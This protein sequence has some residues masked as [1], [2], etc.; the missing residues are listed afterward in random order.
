MSTQRTITIEPHKSGS[1]RKNDFPKNYVSTTKYSIWNIVPKNLFEQFQRVANFWFLTVSI[2]QILPMNLS[3][4][5]KWATITPLSV[6]L[7]ITFCKDAYEDYRRHRDDHRVNN[8]FCH[9]ADRDAG[10]RTV[11]WKDVNVGDYVYLS[12][13][14]PIPADMIMLGTCNEDGVAYVDTAQLDGE[15]SLKP[16]FALEETMRMTADVKELW[17]LSGHIDTELPNA[18]VQSFNGAFFIHGHPR[19]I[20]VDIKS[21]ILRGSTVRNTKWVLGVVVFTG[22]DTKLVRNSKRTPAK[23]SHVERTANRLLGVV[24]GVLLLASAICTVTRAIWTNSEGAQATNW[25]WPQGLDPLRDNQ[26]LAFI[27]FM[28][29]YN[30]LIPI[31]LYVT[32][33]LVRTFQALLMEQDATMYHK[34]TDSFCRV[35]NSGLCESLGQVEFVLSDKTGTLT[36]NEMRFKACSIHGKTYGCWD[37]RIGPVEHH[38][39]MPP[40]R[41]CKPL[42]P[43]MCKPA[44]SPMDGL[45]LGTIQASAD[46]ARS[47]LAEL[48]PILERKNS[49]VSVDVN[50]GHPADG[51]TQS[52]G[53]TAGSSRS[54][55]GGLG[56]RISEM[57]GRK[58]SAVMPMDPNGIQLRGSMLG[59]VPPTITSEESLPGTSS[60]DSNASRIQ[61]PDEEEANWTAE[62]KRADEFFTCLATCHTVIPELRDPDRQDGPK[63]GT[64]EHL[65]EEAAS[66]ILFRSSSPDEEALIAA[67]RDYGFFFR[68]KKG[69]SIVVNVRGKDRYYEILVLNEFSSERKRM[70][71]LVRRLDGPPDSRMSNTRSKS[72]KGEESVTV[73]GGESD[74]EDGDPGSHAGPTQD[75]ARRKTYPAVLYAKGADN[76]MMERFAKVG[77]SH[78]EEQMRALNE[79]LNKFAS[80]GLRTLVVAKRE[81]SPDETERFVQKSLEAKGAILNRNK[82]FEQVADEM[83]RNF[84]LLGITAIEDKIQEQV[85]QTIDMLL[86]AGIKVWVLTGDKTETAINV[87]VACRLIDKSMKQY[88]LEFGRNKDVRKALVQVYNDIREQRDTHDGDFKYCVVVHGSDLYTIMQ[89]GEVLMQQLFLAI[90][91]SSVSVIACRLAPAQKGELVKLVRNSLQGNPVTLSIGD[92]ANDVSMIQE[93]HVGVGIVGLEGLQAANASDFAMG[94]FCFL[95]TLLLCHGRWNLRRIGIVICYS[96]YKNF[97]M[98]LPMFYFTFKN[99]FSG[100]TLFDSYLLMSYNLFFTSLPIMFTGVLDVDCSA[101]ICLRV[102]ALYLGG[103]DRHYFNLHMFVTWIGRGVIHAIAIF[104]VMISI[105]GTDLPNESG[106]TSDMLV[107]GSW[108][109]WTC[110]VVANNKLLLSVKSVFKS[111]VG[112]FGFSMTIFLPLLAFYSQYPLQQFGLNQDM[113]GVAPFL[114]S[115]PMS[116]MGLILVVSFCFL[117]DIALK[118]AHKVFNPDPIDI[119]QEVQA[120]Y[121]TGEWETSLHG[122]P[123][124]VSI[125]REPRYS[126]SR[127]EIHSLIKSLP[128]PSTRFHRL[129]AHGGLRLEPPLLP[130]SSDGYNLGRPSAASSPGAAL[131]KRVSILDHLAGSPHHGGSIL[132][133][134]LP[135]QSQILPAPEGGRASQVSMAP[136]RRNDVS[137]GPGAYQSDISDDIGLVL[138]AGGPEASIYLQICR[139]LEAIKSWQCVTMEVGDLGD[140]G[141][142]PMGALED[143]K[144]DHGPQ[145]AS[146][147]GNNEKDKTANLAEEKKQQA[148]MMTNNSKNNLEY[149]MFALSFTNSERE[150]EF[151]KYFNKQAAMVCTKMMILCCAAV[152]FFRLFD[153]LIYWEELREAPMR[154]SWTLMTIVGCFAVVK[155]TRTRLFERN[156]ISYTLVGMVTI[157]TGVQV[158]HVVSG[159]NGILSVSVMLMIFCGGFRI[160]FIHALPIALY[161]NIVFFVRYLLFFNFIE[162]KNRLSVAQSGPEMVAEYVI[163][164]LGV[165]IFSLHYSYALEKSIR[166][167]FVMYDSLD[168]SKQRALAHLRGMFPDAVVDR[169]VDKFRQEEVR[170]RKQVSSMTAGDSRFQDIEP[171]YEDRGTVTVLF[172][173]IYDFDS[174]TESLQ[175]TELVTLLD[176]VFSMFDRICD[177]RRVV[178]IETV[179][180]TYMSCAMSAPP[181]QDDALGAPHMAD[182]LSAVLMAIDMLELVKKSVL[183]CGNITKISVKIGINTGRVFSGVVGS[184]KPQYALFGDTVNTAARMCSNGRRN[185][186]HISESTYNLVC[187]DER[188][189]WEARQ[190]YAKGKGNLNTYLL[191]YN[192]SSKPTP[193]R[194]SATPTQVSSKLSDASGALSPP[195]PSP[196]DVDASGEP[197]SGSASILDTQVR[198]N[199]T[200]K[201]TVATVG[202]VEEG[203]RDSQVDDDDAKGSPSATETDAKQDDGKEDIHSLMKNR[204]SLEFRNSSLEKEFRASLQSES[205]SLWVS[206]L[207]FWLCYLAS[208]LIIVAGRQGEHANELY[209]VMSFRLGYCFLFLLISIPVYHQVQREKKIDYFQCMACIVVLGFLVSIISNTFWMTE[210][211]KFSYALE[212]FFFITILAHN[213]GLLFTQGALLTTGCVV[214]TLVS[215]GWMWDP[216]ER[217]LLV[218]IIVMLVICQILQLVA[219]QIVEERQRATFMLGRGIREE[220]EKANQLLDSMLPIEVLAELKTGNLSLAYSYE[221]MSLLFADI[222][223]FTSFASGRP[224]YQVVQ[225]VTR[226]FA[227]FDE[228]TLELGVYKVHTI[229]DAYVVVNQPKRVA[230]DP[231]GDALRVYHM[232]ERMLSAIIRV[233]QEVKHDKLDMRI[234]LH[235]GKFCAGVIG[236]KRL[237]FDVWGPD[238]L[239]GNLVESYGVPGALC[240]SEPAKRVLQKAYPGKHEFKFQ[241]NIPLENKDS[242][243]SYQIFKM[244]DRSQ[245]PSGGLAIA[246]RAKTMDD[247]ETE[248]EDI[249]DIKSTKSDDTLC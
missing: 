76:I 195:G 17:G 114:F 111:L 105:F 201:G 177:R 242:L 192:Q 210:A 203:N 208:S 230:V 5:N 98:V 215:V 13:D 1:D 217:D 67:A 170:R 134:T 6:V 209:V 248:E 45:G 15:T 247:P 94:R 108:A 136:A 128:W 103:I 132:V 22:I 31:S 34:V 223:G 96:F 73:S 117:S 129:R 139:V 173:D 171:I 175:A 168:S 205:R 14:S 93:A 65:L 25:V 221:D 125:G 85:P 50:S 127:E 181:S 241:C 60:Q 204:Y 169:V 58:S 90:A 231:S 54:L 35:R 220:H 43:I 213:C 71:V 124:T 19:G 131:S 235:Y 38:V 222:V 118:F 123:T 245:T 154:L 81:L 183:G 229:G 80:C 23:R 163:L 72:S 190:V 64:K 225:L 86:K 166:M 33:D 68:R 160:R 193:N 12:C 188:F 46:S 191:V 157:I 164:E 36:E 84:E 57:L 42:V 243:R 119:F 56:R 216:A 135:R 115:H 121:L 101:D 83:E 149:S 147:D 206:F 144:S 140:A 137:V 234:G 126:R 158:Q 198:V 151:N 184:K 95:S 10:W 138:G 11:R 74:E 110:V 8:Q 214:V 53:P 153:I 133:T 202:S 44:E 20:P 167:E 178:K 88:V 26:Y 233:R 120:G 18:R 141:G 77:S 9:V 109:Y 228:A 185:H 182:A 79:H 28:I 41:V 240:A 142:A 180:K 63:P 156:V 227:E 189:F 91:C 32:L 155:F 112:I 47:S 176:R 70:S 150:K 196:D 48:G 37:D 78:H 122:T 24:F 218:E 146:N 246:A 152:V 29:L 159:Y 89:E 186:L 66:G 49:N 238:V 107:M 200:K 116:W 59:S 7:F 187:Q 52:R 161:H 179:G 165:T 99:A 106:K 197:L 61:D 30:N 62:E 51:S 100:T 244:D 224:V 226:L 211:F 219:M 162:E 249:E 82:L 2:F 172:C 3:P 27:T 199:S 87:G 75:E 21:F 16:K 143:A 148:R 104:C 102:P 232:G 239:A 174:L 130:S 236:T 113:I 145:K 39:A 69:N 237:R 55:A 97:C 194:K 207:S 4:T 92:G 40:P 212:V